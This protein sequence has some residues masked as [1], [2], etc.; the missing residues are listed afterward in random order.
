V[1]PLSLPGIQLSPS[2]P[3]S[4]PP[5][6]SKLIL[7]R[8]LRETGCGGVDWI[9]L[10]QDKDQGRALVNTVVKFRGSVNVRKFL[11]S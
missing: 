2:C 7:R 4:V 11:A 6:L 5:E 3:F 1:Q 8:I 10:A 9:H